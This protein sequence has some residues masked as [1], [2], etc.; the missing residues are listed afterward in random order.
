MRLTLEEK[1]LLTNVRELDG[2]ELSVEDDDYVIAQRL[3]KKS[4]VVMSGARG[5]GRKFIRVVPVRPT[6]PVEC[7]RAVKALLLSS[8]RD[9]NMTYSLLTKEEQGCITAE[10][11]ATLLKWIQS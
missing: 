9:I 5:P 4:L 8:W 11:H 7:E 10:E 3:Q 2:I 6:I 1:D